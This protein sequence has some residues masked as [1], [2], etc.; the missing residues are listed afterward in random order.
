MSALPLRKNSDGPSITS[1]PSGIVTCVRYSA[2]SSMFSMLDAKTVQSSSPDESEM[3]RA[4]AT[5]AVVRVREVEGG[6]VT[7]RIEGSSSP[8][9]TRAR[10]KPGEA[11]LVMVFAIKS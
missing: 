8:C 6:T 1:G 11:F 2:S 7:R 5:D 3:K 9:S 4:G 10:N